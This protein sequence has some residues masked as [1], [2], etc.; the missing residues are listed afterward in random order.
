MENQLKNEGYV[1]SY[2]KIAEQAVYSTS[3]AC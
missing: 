1:G 2:V 3:I